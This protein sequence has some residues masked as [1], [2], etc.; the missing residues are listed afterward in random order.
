MV[1]NFT[2]IDVNDGSGIRPA[3]WIDL[4]AFTAD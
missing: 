3:L 1:G 4:G 2:G